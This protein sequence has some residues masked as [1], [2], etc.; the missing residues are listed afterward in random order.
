[1]EVHAHTHTPRKKWTHY[2]W[3]FIMLFLAVFCGFLAE[4]LR[5]HQVEH[6]REKQFMKLM[7]EDLYTDTAELKDALLHA[8]SASLYS[9]SVL[10]FLSTFK[11][12]AEVPIKLGHD[13]SFAGQ[14]LK[15]INTDRTS[16]QLKNSGAMRIIRK[17]SVA[18]A[19]LLYWK[20][21][22]ETR[23]T[24]DRYLTYRDA[25]RETIFKLWVVPDIYIRAQHIPSDSVKSTRVIEKD[26]HQWD[27]LAN[28]IA[29]GGGI[30]RQAYSRNLNKQ[31]S[32]AK[33]L[34]VLIKKEYDL[35]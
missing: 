22:E 11:P 12:A 27:Y 5:E 31:F 16:S 4:N 30:A 23:I 17:E 35:K 10:M 2:L 6:H 33:A 24:L 3:E 29:M 13:I 14:R 28:M 1:M 32:M 34:I 7:V 26:P 25:G 8:D 15:L 18:N 9:D 21:I 19:L 20:Q